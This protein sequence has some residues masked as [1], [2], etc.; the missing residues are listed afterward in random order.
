MQ[1]TMFK[2]LQKSKSKRWNVS[3]LSPWARTPPWC[4]PR[5]WCPA[6]GPCRL[7]TA[8]WRERGKQRAE[9]KPSNNET[10]T[11]KE[12]GWERKGEEREGGER[13]TE[14]QLFHPKRVKDEK[15]LVVWRKGFGTSFKSAPVPAS[16]KLSGTS[17]M[18]SRRMASAFV[19]AYICYLCVSMCFYLKQLV[20]CWFWWSSTTALCRR[21]LNGL[22]CGFVLKASK[23]NEQCICYNISFKTVGFAGCTA[24]R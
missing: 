6:S 17:R 8:E 21:G 18:L 19:C 7:W 11:R 5:S 24:I 22:A 1:D 16:I 23:R 10:H 13:K 14:F 2:M 20:C 4:R 9:T 12:G 15:R 3:S